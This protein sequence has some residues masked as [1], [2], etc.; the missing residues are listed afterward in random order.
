MANGTILVGD[1]RECLKDYFERY[2]TDEAQGLV[3]RFT[4]ANGQTIK[5]WD[6]G[7][8]RP[9]G[10]LLLKLRCFLDLVGYRVIEF[11]ELPDVA[12]QFAR[13]IA[14]D[15]FSLEDAKQALDYRDIRAVYDVLL[16]SQGLMRDRALR[17]ER[18]VKDNLGLLNEADAM[19]RPIIEEFKLNAVSNVSKVADPLVSLP[20]DVVEEEPAPVLAT[21]PSP[22]VSYEPDSSYDEAK[23]VDHMVAALSVLL[24]NGVQGN[25]RTPA[26]LPGR[27]RKRIFDQIG[28]NRLR[29]LIAKLEMLS[30]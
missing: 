11:E 10:E 16:R 21:L 23:V 20:D 3:A 12:R 13:L 29:K 8:Y 22:V 25:D 5:D 28:E 14:Y 7:K 17:L 15:I 18:N 4:G 27:R 24:D 19:W 26:P 30:D 6:T 9:N 2:P 1:T